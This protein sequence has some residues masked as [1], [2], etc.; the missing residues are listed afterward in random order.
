MSRQR[1]KLAK[2]DPVDGSWLKVYHNI[3]NIPII[4]RSEFKSQLDLD[5][6]P[7]P[8]QHVMDLD[9][10][11][12]QNYGFESETLRKVLKSEKHS[13]VKC[14]CRARFRI[15]YSWIRIRAKY[16]DP[17]PKLSEK[18]ICIEKQRYIFSKS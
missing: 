9:P 13:S 16:L 6:H 2:C 1:G 5:P 4:L 10:V 18:S 15:R 17:D 8:F 14:F 12:Y 11:S 3:T 7:D